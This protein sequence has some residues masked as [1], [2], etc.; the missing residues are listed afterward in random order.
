MYDFNTVFKETQPLRD[1]LAEQEK[2]LSEKMAELAVKKKA[3]QDVNDK[4]AHL[5]ATYRAKLAEK[6]KLENDIK[7]CELKLD[8]AQKLTG[9]LSDEKVRWGHDV[10]VLQSR[11]PLI[12]GD[13]I[14]GA[15]MVAYS[16]PF[17]AQ[18]R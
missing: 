8:R 11:E 15:G 16:G 1:K 17:T 10:G 13:S 9:G 6:E 14:I 3:L 2:I 12:L 7:M 18:Y 5:E 4:I